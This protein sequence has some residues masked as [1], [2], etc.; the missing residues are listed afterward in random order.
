MPTRDIFICHA[1]SDRDTHAIPLRQELDSTGV[2]CW[3]DEA[4][5]APGQSIA[6]AIGDGIQSSD[7]V[8]LL[9]TAE[10]LKPGYRHLEHRAAL[11]REI[12][13]RSDVVIPILD[14]SYQTFAKHLPLLADK[15]SLC[16][17]NGPQAVAREISRKR[18]NRIPGNEWYCDHALDY[19]GEVWVRITPSERNRGAIHR[20]DLRWGAF[21]RSLRVTPLADGAPVSLKHT[22]M[23]D[24]G[25]TLH[26]SATPKAIVTFGQ[27]VPPDQPA[28]NINEGWERVCGQTWQSNWW[29]RD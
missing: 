15:H 16:W 13:Q 1:R 14:V 22:K 7:F 12:S 6:C 29:Q 24:D 2:S 19:K 11:E 4:V 25:R 9:V 23:A 10:F 3:V 20:V 27:G 17:D 18:F 8:V 28:I 21:H 5:L 26:V